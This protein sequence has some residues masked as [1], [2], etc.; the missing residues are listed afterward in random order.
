M[1]E[2]V[3]TLQIQK[4]HFLEYLHFQCDK[5]ILTFLIS[6]YQYFDIIDIFR[7]FFYHYENLLDKRNECTN[8]P[9]SLGSK[10]KNGGSGE[11]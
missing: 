2:F 9:E 7:Y 11:M 10:F 5:S 4:T 1:N 6:M 3:L 8:D